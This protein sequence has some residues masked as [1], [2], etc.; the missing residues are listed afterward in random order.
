M[1]VHLT[2]PEVGSSTL[3]PADLP[4]IPKQEAC[5]KLS[6]AEVEIDIKRSCTRIHF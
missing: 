6:Q 1:L 5:G 4:D 3:I 2:Q